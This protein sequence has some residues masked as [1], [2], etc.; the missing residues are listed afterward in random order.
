LKEI[1]DESNGIKRPKEIIKEKRNVE[2]GSIFKQG[3]IF[4]IGDED[5]FVMD[6]E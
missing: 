4:S 6:E 1:E 5:R 3:M 2:I